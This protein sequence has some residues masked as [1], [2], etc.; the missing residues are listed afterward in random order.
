[1]G[2]GWTLI[3]FLSYFAAVGGATQHQIHAENLEYD[4]AH[5]RDRIAHGKIGHFAIDHF[6][7][8]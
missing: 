2:I 8:H 3:D 5:A 7:K 4:F 1:M 6:D